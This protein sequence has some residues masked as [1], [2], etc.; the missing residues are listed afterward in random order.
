MQAIIGVDIGTTSTKTAL[1]DRT[2]KILAQE[3]LT[4]PLYE[5]QVDYAEEDPEQI[6]TAVLQGITAVSAVANRRH[7]TITGV[8][9]SA[10]MHSLIL[11]DGAHQPLTRV[12]TWADNRAI[13]QSQALEDSGA[14]QCLYLKTGTPNHP[15]TPLAKLIW[16]REKQPAL[17]KQ[18]RHVSGIKGYI[19]WR[20]FGQ[21]VSDYGIASTTGMFDSQTLTWEPQALAL[22]GLTLK[23]LPQLVATETLFTGLSPAIATQLGLSESVPFIIGSSDG[24]LANLGVGA[25]TSDTLAVSIGTSGALRLVVDHPIFDPTG[26]LF[27][28]VVDSRRWVVGGPVNNGGIVLQWVLEQWF[29]ETAQMTY[30]EL[31]TLAAQSVPGAHGLIFLPYLGGER[32]PIWNPEAR[33]TL[34]G[35]TRKHTQADMVRAVL[36]GVIFNLGAVKQLVEKRVGPFNKIQATGGF[37]QTNLGMQILADCFNQPVEVA[38]R[39]MGSAWGAALLGFQALGIK[40]IELH[41]EP[42]TSP[43]RWHPEPESVV[44][45]QELMT[46]WQHCGDALALQYHQIAQ[47]QKKYN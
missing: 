22:T 36:E 14:A 38:K 24:A 30:P 45:Y 13:R 4:Y 35:L 34:L 18:V 3:N 29:P 46:I 26:K 11:L 31:M 7:I 42:M 23:Q 37:T 8:S 47:F 21:D 44:R 16:F 25:T 32:A 19:F 41:E 5:P 40:P 28:Y 10:A 20:L 15:M 39:A 27:C 9:F 1:F 33:G 43:Q 17:F 6:L 2:G 12:I